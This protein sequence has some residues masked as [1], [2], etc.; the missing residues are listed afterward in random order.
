LSRYITKND[1]I[2]GIKTK[3]NEYTANQIFSSAGLPETISLCD[4]AET[5]KAPAVGNMSFMES[6][7]ITD[8]KIRTSDFDSTIIFY[9]DSSKYHYKKSDGL[10]DSRSAVFC[11]PDNYELENREGEGTLRVTF[12]A[13]YEKWKNLAKTEYKEKK[14]LVNIESMNLI[15]KLIPNFDYEVRFTDVFS[16]TTVERY[17]SHFNGTVYGSTDKS[18]DGKTPIENLYIIGTDQGFLGIV[19]SM[20]SG[21]SIANLYGLME[22]K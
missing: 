15:K 2:I 18:R 17:T 3:K 22:T 4:G 20:L 9:N 5:L 19:G 13:N 7:I 11:C 12:M 14:E 16:P 8:K 6:I 10:F 1:K 21:I